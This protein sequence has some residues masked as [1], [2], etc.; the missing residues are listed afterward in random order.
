MSSHKKKRKGKRK[1]KEKGKG[2]GKWKKEKF[3]EDSCLKNYVLKILEIFSLL[4]GC[5]GC[6]STKMC[7]LWKESIG[8]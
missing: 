2:K 5:H 7:S 6:I 3:L 8:W 1:E 4:M